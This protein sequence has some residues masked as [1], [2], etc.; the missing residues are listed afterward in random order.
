[1]SPVRAVSWRD[2]NTHRLQLYLSSAEIFSI[3]YRFS[4]RRFCY[5]DAFSATKAPDSL[6]SEPPAYND[7]SIAL[8][9]M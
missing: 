5:C 4:T 3:L 2:G 6:A 7:T 1:M 9:G 8:E